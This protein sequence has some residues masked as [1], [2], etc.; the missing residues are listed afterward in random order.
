MRSRLTTLLSVGFIFAG[1]G[2]ALAL[3]GG[4]VLAPAGHERASASFNQY[5]PPETPPV[6][7]PPTTGPPPSTP[8][9]PTPPVSTPPASTFIPRPASAKLS[10]AGSATVRCATV[11]HIVLRARRGSKC[12]HVRVRLHAQ[13]TATVRLPKGAISRLGRGKVLVSVEVDGKVIATRT[14]RLR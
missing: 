9:V 8:P 5:R 10:S 13:G 1:T 12:V 6:P 11:C 2:G 4:G 3:G 7:T 14:L